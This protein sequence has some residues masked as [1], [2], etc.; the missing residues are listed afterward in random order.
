MDKK[1]GIVA[2]VVGIV[3]GLIGV[4]PI[5]QG[6]QPEEVGMLDDTFDAVDESFS[7][8]KIKVQLLYDGAEDS[9]KIVIHKIKFATKQFEE[10]PCVDYIP[11]DNTSNYDT[12]MF[13]A[14]QGT[15]AANIVEV[16]KSGDGELALLYDNLEE[17][18][19]NYR[20]MDNGGYP[21]EKGFSF[22]M[23]LYVYWFNIDEPDVLHETWYGANTVQAPLVCG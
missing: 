15:G 7:P 12:L 11:E 5:L 3:V 22:W 13:R 23:G 14:T 2:S 8:F 9:N 10:V 4:V 21:I 18:T 6:L 1:L 16:T 20:F 19:F 17:M